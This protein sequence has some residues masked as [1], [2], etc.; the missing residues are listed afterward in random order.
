VSAKKPGIFGSIK[1]V[2]NKAPAKVQ[3]PIKPNNTL[4]EVLNKNL[5]VEPVV[6]P[7]VSLDSLKTPPPKP[8]PI[9]QGSDRAA[10]SEDMS[11]LKNFISKKIEEAKVEK[12]EI[13]IPTPA[14]STASGPAAT[15]TPVTPPT[16]PVPP[17][18]PLQN[19][20]YAKK[21]KEV[22]EDVLRKILE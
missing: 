3:V 18:T 7:A 19:G 8:A 2:F 17:P 22:P 1:K 6:P 9:K 14:P 11:N 4:R 13:P 10:S 15:P 16:P 5:K 12:K 21:A 20:S